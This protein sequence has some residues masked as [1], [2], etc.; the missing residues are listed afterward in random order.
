MNGY[1]IHH[2]RAI[3]RQ[4]AAIKALAVEYLQV[5][6]D[7]QAI[8]KMPGWDSPA[9]SA[10]RA[11]IQKILDEAYSTAATLQQIG[12]DLYAFTASHKTWLEDIIDAV[13]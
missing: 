11:E 12:N 2:E 3:N 5:I 13:T 4:A 8:A 6:D 9:A 10:Q 1:M 7:A